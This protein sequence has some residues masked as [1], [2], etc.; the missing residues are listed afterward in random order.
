MMSFNNLKVKDIVKDEDGIRMV[1]AIIE[2]TPENPIYC[3]S[4][5]S[6]FDDPSYFISAKGMSKRCFSIVNIVNNGEDLN[7]KSILSQ[8]MDQG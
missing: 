1:L 8:V 2:S 6:D 5:L 3:L 7:R 4:D